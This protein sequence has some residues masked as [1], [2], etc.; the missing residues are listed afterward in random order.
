MI[1][2]DRGLQ[3]KHQASIP[4]TGFFRARNLSPAGAG[5]NPAC[6]AQREAQLPRP[7][8]QALDQD[9]RTLN[10][11]MGG[12]ACQDGPGWFAGERCD[13]W[14]ANNTASA[15][16]A[17]KGRLQFSGETMSAKPRGNGLAQRER[18][19]F[20]IVP[21]ISM[22]RLTA[23]VHPTKDPAIPAH[24]GRRPASGPSREPCPLCIICR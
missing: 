23:S 17:S 5:G 12:P 22:L 15:D 20:E 6:P 9:R 4:S 19:T 8:G 24:L 18:P 7:A 3:R 13:G 1:L 10:C 2:G 11:I 14:P 21:L 16:Q